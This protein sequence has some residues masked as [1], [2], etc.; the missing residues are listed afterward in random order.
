M[1]RYENYKDLQGNYYFKHVYIFKCYFIVFII[2]K[3]CG[4]KQIDHPFAILKF[5]GEP[6]NR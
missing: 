3:P 2:L 6:I 5:E 4:T 1:S